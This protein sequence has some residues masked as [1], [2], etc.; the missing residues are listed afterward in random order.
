VGLG[1]SERDPNLVNF[2]RCEIFGDVVDMGSQ[3]SNIVQV[4]GNGSLGTRP[5]AVAF[6]VYADVVD[7]GV[8]TCEAHCIVAFTAGELN[9]YGVLIAKDGMPVSFG[10]FSIL[11]IESVGE[12][13]VLRKFDEFGFAHDAQRYCDL[14][15]CC[16]NINFVLCR[17]FLK[18][19]GSIGWRI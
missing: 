12:G 4:L 19:R 14:A 13:S 8:K 17:Q 16:K 11:D 18:N 10:C 5:H 1:V 15:I 2:V 7:I 3:E 6:D 9:Y